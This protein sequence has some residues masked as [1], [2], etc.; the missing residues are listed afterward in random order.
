MALARLRTIGTLALLGILALY[1]AVPTDVRAEESTVDP[2]ATKILQ[3]TTDY[4]GGLDKFSLD[5]ENTLEDVLESGQKIQY[6]F[7]TSVVI[8]RPNKLRAE[9]KGDLVDQVVVYDGKTLT[10]FDAGKNYYAV[11]EA[12]DNIDSVLHFARDT[13]DI[14]P[15]S[16]D[17][18]YTNAFDLLMAQV[19]SGMV[20]GKSIIGGVRCDHLAFSGPMVDWQIWIADGKQPL[21][22]KYVIT[23]KDD[24]AQP[25][26]I[27]MMSN[28]NVAPDLE[29]AAFKFKAPK[30]AEKIDFL[31]MD[32]GHT[33]MD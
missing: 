15:P 24:P 23:T 25:Q 3:R 7:G 14:V 22:Y 29:D 30:C 2:A 10:I 33:S 17:L 6:D 32:A 27:V 26:Y 31:R 1:L 5:T 4:L 20:V 16:G 8:Q 18:I 12:P 21:P 9:R 28:W 11:A 19:T 13:L